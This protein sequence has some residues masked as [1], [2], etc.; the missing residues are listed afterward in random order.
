MQIPFVQASTSA[1]QR[2]SS[3]KVRTLFLLQCSSRLIQIPFVKPSTMS[4][5]PDNSNKIYERHL[6]LKRRGFPLWIPTPN[7]N[8]L[9]DYQ[10]EGIN[11]GDVGFITD[12]GGFSFLFNICHPPDH[13]INRSPLPDGFTQ[14]Q[15]PIERM[16]INENV[17]FNPGCHLGSG[18]KEVHD[19]QIS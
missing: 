8:L 1:Q 4:Y 13:P 17:A 7:R 16:D 18:I 6:Q 2:Q 14:I 9:R 15:P 12:A 19:P 11:I 3:P 10:R 5:A